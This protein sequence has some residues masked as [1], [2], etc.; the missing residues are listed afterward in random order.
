VIFTSEIEPLRK[1]QK[2]IKI[3]FKNKQVY[4][5]HVIKNCDNKVISLAPWA[6]TSMVPKGI[7]FFKMND[8][9]TGFLPNK[10]IIT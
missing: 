4:V 6:L 9:D 2:Q 10:K 7:A 1:L 8:K 3:M 5:E